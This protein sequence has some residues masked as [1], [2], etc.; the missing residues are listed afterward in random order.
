[1]SA[2]ISLVIPTYNRADL[3]RETITSALNQRQPFSEII[4]VD[5]G[6]TDNTAEVLASYND[7]IRI[8][9]SK[10][11][12]VQSARN[13]GV[14]AAFSEYVTFCDSDDLLEPE[15]VHIISNWFSISPNCDATYINFNHFTEK[16]VN[17][18]DFSQAPSHFL[19]GA[20]T[21]GDF[22]YDIPDLYLRLFTVHPF[23]ITGCTV[24]KSFFNS[25]GGFNTLFNRVGAEDGEFTLRV[26]ASGKTAFCKTPLAKVR[27]HIGNESL[28]PLHVI[29][30][31]AKILEYASIHHENAK[32]YKLALR[33][34][35]NKLRLEAGNA[36]FSKGIFDVAQQM[37]KYDFR[38]RMGVKFQL[39]KAI[40][41]LPEPLRTLAW[42]ATQA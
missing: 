39:K 3:I 11:G 4:V 21:K 5:D 9:H 17:P 14:A 30:G 31:S 18:D 35:A 26:A 29:T 12:G 6:S 36:A 8:I 28:N 10:N 42:K 25:I 40:I 41:S 32:N 33:D 23:Y 1:M 13:K 22:A 34:Q 20:K 27:R 2:S 15:F 7:Q 37:F 38:R 24:K 19:Y 16:A